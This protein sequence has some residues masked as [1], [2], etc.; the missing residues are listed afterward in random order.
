VETA[1]GGL[2][3]A[4]GSKTA[5]QAAYER[6][7]ALDASEA[8]ALEGLGKIAFENK[9]VAK[10][11]SYYERA[12]EASPQARLAK[13]LGSLRLE[14]DDVPGAKTAFKRALELAPDDPDADELRKIIEGSDP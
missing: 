14:A 6:A 2:E 9:D 1:L 4:R 10:A 5:A 11:I 12:L 3:Q 13:T 7:L 8:R